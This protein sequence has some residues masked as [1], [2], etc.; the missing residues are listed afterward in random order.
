MPYKDPVKAREHANKW[1][2]AW[3]AANKEKV[4]ER[5]RRWAEAHPEK[6]KEAKRRYNA[7]H[8]EK[9]KEDHRRW[10]AAHPENVRK[11]WLVW[12]ANNPEKART[13]VQR[14]RINNPGKRAVNDHNRR[15]RLRGGG[16]HTLEQWE[17]LQTWC[18]EICLGCRR[19]ERELSV[20]DLKIVR[21]HVVAV[22]KGGTNNIN[23][24]QPLCHGK[25]GCNNRKGASD[26]D[27]R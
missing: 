3:Y 6:V 26:T 20:L 19:T 17:D 22:A 13:R 10:V 4:K 1:G 21:D 11:K 9:V 27:F 8:P 24:I 14:W 18:G 2:K 5:V 15:V 7:A 16:T 23:N 25:G 12:C